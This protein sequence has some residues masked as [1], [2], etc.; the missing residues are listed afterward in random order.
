VISGTLTDRVTVNRAHRPPKP[1]VLV[2]PSKEGNVTVVTS[3]GSVTQE[4][5]D[6]SMVRTVCHKEMHKEGSRR[7]E[8]MYTTL[9]SLTHLTMGDIL[10]NRT[11]LW[12]RWLTYRKML[13]GLSQQ[14]T[15]TMGVTLDNRVPLWSR[16][17]TYH[18]TRTGHNRR[19]THKE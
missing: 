15:T 5:M 7:K 8:V 10:D 16:W 6:L 13:T 14:Y 9:L 12:S 18:R 11:P 17:L 19:Y 2:S 3:V 4:G 1:G